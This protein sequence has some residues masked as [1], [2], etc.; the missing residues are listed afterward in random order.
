MVT[1]SGS[2]CRGHS[3]ASSSVERIP[4]QSCFVVKL[5]R[6]VSLKLFDLELPNWILFHV[7][8]SFENNYESRLFAENSTEA[9]W[10]NSRTAWLPGPL[11]RI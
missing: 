9:H 8:N 3:G 6:N 2:F 10:K 11:V 7:S 5:F 4:D 1:N